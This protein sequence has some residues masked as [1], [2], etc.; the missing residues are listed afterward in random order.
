M[1]AD[2][3][4]I[5]FRDS[6]PELVLRSSVNTAQF[7]FYVVKQVIALLIAIATSVVTILSELYSLVPVFIVTL[8]AFLFWFYYPDL[9][10][11]LSTTG[12]QLLNLFFQLFQLFWY[13][14]QFSL[15]VLTHSQE[16]GYHP[17]GTVCHGLEWCA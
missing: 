9:Q 1:N 2:Q 5:W 17:M 7:A 16:L 14:R 13:V 4:C 15:W 11:F 6:Y 10:P 3:W 8:F 12:V